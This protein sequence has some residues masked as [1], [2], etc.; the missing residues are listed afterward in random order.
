VKVSRS[1]SIQ[2][3]LNFKLGLEL[4]GGGMRDGVTPVIFLVFISFIYYLFN[5]NN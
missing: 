2:M 1:M 4:I 3:R 5:V